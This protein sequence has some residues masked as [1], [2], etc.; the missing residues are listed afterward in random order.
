MAPNAVRY[1]VFDVESAADPDLVAA[2]ASLLAFALM[3]VARRVVRWSP[4][5]REMA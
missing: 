1:L 5:E 2:P 4:G 3:L